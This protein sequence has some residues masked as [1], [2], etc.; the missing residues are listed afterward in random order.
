MPVTI[1][2]VADILLANPKRIKKIL[3]SGELAQRFAGRSAR[4]LKQ[5]SRPQTPLSIDKE[6]G[7]FYLSH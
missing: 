7:M 6:T 2:T 3:G 5:G 4:S 1:L